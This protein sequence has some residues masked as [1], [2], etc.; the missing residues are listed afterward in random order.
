VTFSPPYLTV[1]GGASPN[2]FEEISCFIG[3]AWIVGFASYIPGND[4]STGS[5]E[6]RDA[7]PELCTRNQSSL[8]PNQT[9]FTHQWFHA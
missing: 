7:P 9:G 5:F 8:Q 1:E 6:F 3:R 2:R 4:T